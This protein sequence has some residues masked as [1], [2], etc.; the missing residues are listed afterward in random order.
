[1]DIRLSENIRRLR[2]ERHIT[3]EALSEALGVTVGAVYKW[4][5]GLS[6][7]E[8]SMLIRLAELFDVSVDLLLG[9]NLKDNHIESM[10][11]RILGF[12][13]AKDRSGIEEAEKALVKF[14]N[15]YWVVYDSA[16]MYQGFGLED[17]NMDY[18]RRSNELFER[19]VQI[20]PPDADPRFGELDVRGS[21]AT[22]YYFLNETEKAIE[23][24]QKYNQ[25]GV[26]NA[27]LGLMK[28]MEEEDLTEG[29]MYLTQSFLSAISQM[30]NT[31]L[32][33][34]TIYERTGDAKKLESISRFS[35][36]FFSSLKKSDSPS[37]LDKYL[38]AFYTFQSH[39]YFLAGEVKKAEEVLMQA[40]DLAVRFDAHP[41]YRVSSCRFV[42]GSS[43]EVMSAYDALGKTARDGIDFCVSL[44]ESKKFSKLWEKVRNS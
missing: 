39:A 17:K 15:D 16:C 12:I 13:K 2:K 30:F 11:K 22:N 42:E 31:I 24:L 33:F 26:F 1:M 14:P 34:V 43:E 8:I 19:A 41:D 21:I 29:T 40:K 44:I 25:A 5:A 23:Q 35:I 37:Y 20:I 3:Q 6:M 4:E 18:L 27:N 36:K 28:V 7:P 9:Y 32:G 38:C 10:R